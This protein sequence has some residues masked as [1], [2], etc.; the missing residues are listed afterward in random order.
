MTRL[1]LTIAQMMG[2]VLLVGFGFAALRNADRFWASA[3]FGLAV[4]SVSAALVGAYAR[5]GS[6]RM[7]WAGFATTGG[8][9]LATWLSS[10]QTVGSLSGPPQTLLQPI[11]AKFQPYINPA[12]FGGA[13]FV[14]YTQIG[15]SLSVI[16][17]ALV[18]AVVGRLVAV[19][20]DRANP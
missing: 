12:A 11:L 19:K 1:R 4:I 9:C 10:A 8:A 5:K 3:A 18:G 20:D 14:T 7:S 6:A 13:A 17:L 2:S 16:L 15:N